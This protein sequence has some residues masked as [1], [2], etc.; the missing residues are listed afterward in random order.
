MRLKRSYCLVLGLVLLISG[1]TGLN[2]REVG[3]GEIPT[4]YLAKTCKT[5][6]WGVQ[7]WDL[8]EAIS[9]LK[10]GEKVV[11][12]DTR[13]ASFYKKGS[14]RDA[15]LMPFNKTGAE[16]NELTKAKLEEIIN[17]AGLSRDSARLVFFCQGPK[18]HRSYNA[19]YVA[20][21]K[22]GFKAENVV[23]FRDGYPLLFKEVKENNKLKRK[24]KKY[25]SDDG[26]TQL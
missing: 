12:I 1:A 9:T 8:A 17:K 19:A 16:G 15:V 21:K 2:A 23:W 10:T 7:V 20:A 18:C 13:P 5:L 14:V 26:M 4:D 6:P 22:W 24:A 11:W 3:K 25:L